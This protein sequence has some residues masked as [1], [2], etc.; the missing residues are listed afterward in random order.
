MIQFIKKNFEQLL[1]IVSASFILLSSGI[2]IG[3]YNI[4]PSMLIIS[5]IQLPARWKYWETEFLESFHIKPVKAIIKTDYKGKSLKTCMPQ[6]AYDGITLITAMAENSFGIKLIDLKGKVINTWNVPYSSIWKSRNEPDQK[7]KDWDLEIECALLYPNGDVLFVFNRDSLV[8]IDKDS[9]VIWKRPHKIHH[10]LFEDNEG[11]I[12]APAMKNITLKYKYKN[13]EL[14]L[15]DPEYI[16]KLSPDGEIIEEIDLL[17]SIINSNYKGI[18]SIPFE[19]IDDR[20]ERTKILGKDL[21]HLN[22]IEIIEHPEY[23]NNPL[24]EKGDLLVSLRDTNSLLLIDK[25]TKIVKWV[26]SGSMVHQHDPDIL[27]NGEISIF[28]NRGG[29]NE[30]LCEY[31]SR[32]ITLNPSTKQITSIYEAEND[33][34]FYTAFRGSHQYLPNGNI[35]IVESGKGRLFEIDKNGEIV[36][37]YYDKLDKDNVAL[38]TYALKYPKEYANFIKE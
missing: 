18:L 10:M 17:K 29:G 25:E 21:T 26:E 30:G 8:K 27:P 2:I 23:F 12:W 11:N 9:N 32:I 36:W 5:A 37:D 3:H 19:H 6:K 7:K 22:D 33:G 1:F 24:F 38:I 15:A 34:D 35:F 13:E 16:Y 4:F 20:L 14:I 31:K 28:D